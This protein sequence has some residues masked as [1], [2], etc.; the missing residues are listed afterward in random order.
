MLLTEIGGALPQLRSGRCDGRSSFAYARNKINKY[1]DIFEK[2]TGIEIED[3]HRF[4]L[5]SA[6]DRGLDLAL[7]KL[8]VKADPNAAHA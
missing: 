3:N 5:S 6:I 8:D 7:S 1:L 2:K 4:A